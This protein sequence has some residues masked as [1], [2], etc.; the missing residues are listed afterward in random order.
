MNK[1][2]GIASGF[3]VILAAATCITMQFAHKLENQNLAIVQSMD[4]DVEVRK[5]AGWW[6]QC[7]PTIVE[8]PKAGIYICSKE[9][10][11]QDAFKIQFNNKSTADMN[12]QIGYRIDSASDDKIIKLHQAVEGKDETIWQLIYNTIN[13]EVQKVSST[14]DPSDVIGGEKF[15]EFVAAMQSNILHN[16]ELLESGIDI[17]KFNVNGKPDPDPDTK[18]Q[19]SAQREADLAKRLAMAEK[20]RL[21][22]ERLQTEAN[23]AKQ[24]AEE[25]GKADAETA[26]LKTEAERQKELATIEAEKSKEVARI[27]K[28]RA[29]IEVEKQKSVAKIEAEKLLEVAEIEKKTEAAKL[30]AIEI[31]AKQK[32]ASAEAKKKE[33]ELSGAITEVQQA[34]LEY[35]FKKEQVKWENIGKGIGNIKLPA[36]MTVGGA[37]GSIKQNPINDLIN[38]MTLEKVQTIAAPIKK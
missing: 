17:D 19:F 25:K 37:D 12:C 3:V 23:Y 9:D 32:I 15:P 13:T 28:E 8:Y 6:I 11:D 36:I 7:W 14:F 20:I 5:Q 24:M 31:Q 38:M 10:K 18:K 34:E 30:E 27:E 1:L 21:E 33:I 4:G 22:A 26:R 29:E 2:I 35:N 16:A